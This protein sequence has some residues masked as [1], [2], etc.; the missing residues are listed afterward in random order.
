MS[1]TGFGAWLVCEPE[2]AKKRILYAIKNTDNRSQAA[3]VLGITSHVLKSSMITLGII[4]PVSSE[5]PRQGRISKLKVESESDPEG[6][7]DK[8]TALMNRLGTPKLVAAELGER[9]ETVE[10]I[11]RRLCVR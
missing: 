2:Q 11:M 5:P 4:S 8:L 7:R 9:T 6:V 1:L 10:C 3:R